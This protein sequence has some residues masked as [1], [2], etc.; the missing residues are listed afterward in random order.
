M[1]EAK[2]NTLSKSTEEGRSL[3]VLRLIDILTC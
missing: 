1:L 2:A 3:K